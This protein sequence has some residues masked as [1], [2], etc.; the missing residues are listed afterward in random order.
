MRG[1]RTTKGKRATEGMVEKAS[2][3]VDGCV[4]I[5]CYEGRVG[6]GSLKQASN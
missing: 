1:R 5:T 4:L 3:L 6:L 2:I